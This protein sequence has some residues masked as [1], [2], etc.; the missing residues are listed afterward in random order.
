M[1]WR[2][3]RSDFDKGKGAGNRR[4]LKAIVASGEIPGVLAY[5]QG[6]PIAWCSVAPRETFPVLDRSRTLKP[7]DEQPV[8]SVACLF[9]ARPWR[10]KGVTVRLLQAAAK[11]ARRRGARLLEG[12]PI[13]PKTPAMPDVFAWTG[14]A[15]AFRRAGFRE[16][17]RRSATRPIM[18]LEVRPSRKEAAEPRARS[19]PR[20]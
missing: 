12:Y 10:R 15:S 4:A 8:W 11:Y 18:R 7:V 17:A 1:W 3:R 6:R 5:A 20:L 19:R 13:D 14:L 2:L 16:V 9:V